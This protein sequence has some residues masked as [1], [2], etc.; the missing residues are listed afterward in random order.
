[1]LTSAGSKVDSLA[2]LPQFIQ[3]DIQER[4]PLYA[5]APAPFVVE[6]WEDHSTLRAWPPLRRLLGVVC[7]TGAV[8]GRRGVGQAHIV[9]KN[10]PLC[11][12]YLQ[13]TRNR[14]GA[15]R[16]FQT[17]P[18]GRTSEI[19]SRREFACAQPLAKAQRWLL[20]IF[21]CFSLAAS[22]AHRKKQGGFACVCECVEG[23]GGWGMWHVLFS[24]WAGAC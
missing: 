9:L 16:T 17:R 1:M 13:G 5:I 18:R 8:P 14:P 22:P 15:C 20:Q 11:L 2:D 4:L 21:F 19:T 12:F 6:Q 3:D 7:L 10:A 23:G 24:P